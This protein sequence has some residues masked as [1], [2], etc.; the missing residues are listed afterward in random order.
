[1]HDGTQYDPI[2]GQSYEP[3]KVGNTAIF[4]SYILRH[5]QGRRQVQQS[6]VYN[7]GSGVG[8]GIPQL[9]V[10]AP[11]LHIEIVAAE[12]IRHLATGIPLLALCSLYAVYII[13]H[14]KLF[15]YDCLHFPHFFYN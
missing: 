14:S 4:S 9:G 5:L 1:M 11:A 13:L 12:P 8:R 7:T 15:I 2:Q 6:G 10:G 3:F